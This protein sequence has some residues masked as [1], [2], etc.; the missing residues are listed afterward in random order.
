MNLQEALLQMAQDEKRKKALKGPQNY[1]DY[2]PATL[3]FQPQ[4]TSLKDTLVDQIG[5]RGE[6]AT[7]LEQT[8]AANRQAF[9]RMR[10]EEQKL[11]RARRGLER[12]REQSYQINVDNPS[13]QLTGN[14]P[15]GGTYKGPRKFSRKRWGD[16]RTPQVWD[17]KKLNPHAPITTVEWRGHRF[18]VNRQVAPIFVAF[19]DDLYKMGYRPKSIGGHNDRNIAGTNMPSLHSYGFA[20][21]ID[22]AQNPVTY[23]GVN[24]TILPRRVGQLAAKYGLKWGGNWKSYKDPMH[25]SVAYG[26]RE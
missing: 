22:P 13:I 4:D 17:I 9:A 7:Q 20:I 6:T 18:G 12:A 21:D 2:Q 5:Q 10:E 1:L 11:A 14:L 25:F 15:G 26:G 24:Q 16:D 3:G 23:N 19:L 8:K